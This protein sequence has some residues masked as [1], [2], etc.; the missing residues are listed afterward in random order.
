METHQGVHTPDCVEG[1]RDGSVGCFTIG[2]VSRY[3]DK[4]AEQRLASPD[5]LIRAT[6]LAPR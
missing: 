3:D 6:G 2:A 1:G 5:E 4:R